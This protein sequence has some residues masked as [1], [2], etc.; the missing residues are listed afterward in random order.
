MKASESDFMAALKPVMRDVELSHRSL[1]R[2]VNKPDESSSHAW[3]WTPQ[4]SGVGIFLDQDCGQ[5]SAI[6]CLAEQVQ[7]FVAEALWGA[8]KPTNWPACP[9]HPNRHPLRPETQE[10]RAVWRCPIT[11]DMTATIGD[12]PSE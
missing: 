10:N 7:E 8:G 3:L 2:V 1:I 9:Q 5:A 6:V 11:G 12:L 4:G